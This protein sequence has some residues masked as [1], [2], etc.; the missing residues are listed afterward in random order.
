MMKKTTQNLLLAFSTLL[1]LASVTGSAQGQPAQDQRRG[2]SPSFAG[3]WKTVTPKG[4]TIFMTLRHERADPSLVTGEYMP[5][6]GLT[7]SYKPADSSINGFVKVSWRPEP[8][9]QNIPFISGKVT[10]NVL[11]FTWVEDGGQ[12][13]G[14]FT[15]SSDGESFEGTF[16]MTKNPDDTSGG[17]LNGTRQHSFAGAWQGTWGEGG[18]SELLLVQAR[19]QVTGRFRVNSAELGLIKEGI[20]DGNTLRFKL[21]RPNINPLAGKPDEYLGVGELVMN[22]GGKS[23]KGTI[24]GTAASGTHVGR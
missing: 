22:A 11:R 13:S 12:G 10:D 9:L 21:F 24:L 8:V 3:T 7:G 5:I 15:L 16:S 2:N 18:F 19:Q 23:F 17:T 14:R 20:V 1:L 6:D 4:K